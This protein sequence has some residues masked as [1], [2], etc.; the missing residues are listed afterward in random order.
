MKLETI[1]GLRLQPEQRQGDEQETKHTGRMVHAREKLAVTMKN[2]R[3][4]L[5][6]VATVMLS[7]CSSTC[8]MGY[9][10]KK[11]AIEHVVLAWLKK[12][13]NKDDQARVIAAAKSLKADIKEVKTLAV[14]RA[15]PSDREV[16]DDSFDVALVMR[17]DT[18]ADLASYEKNPVHVKAVTDI[19]KPLTAK[20]VVHDIVS[21]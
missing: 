11:G 19:L 1:K 5:F 7:S 3:S 6:V 13:G 8:P 16:V 15:L 14:G 10:P 2:A 4:I 12:P 21:E 20:I 17:F 18:P 9:G